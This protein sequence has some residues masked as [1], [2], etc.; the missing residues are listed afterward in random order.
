MKSVLFVLPIKKGCAQQ[1]KDI[2]KEAEK[3]KQEYSDCLKRYD[4]LCAKV[5][6]KT[7]AGKD[8]ACVYHETGENFREKLKLF[9]DSKHPFDLWFKEQLMTVYEADPTAEDA[10]EIL[11]FVPE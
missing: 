11:D 10:I 5:W 4:L 8:Y 1:Y 7:L 6:L 3:R 2:I 9:V